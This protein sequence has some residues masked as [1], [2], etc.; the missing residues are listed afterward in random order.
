MPI[1]I[2]DA[3][4]PLSDESL[5]RRGS[6]AE[7][8]LVESSASRVLRQELQ[9]YCEGKINGR[10]FLIAGHR[11]AGKTTLVAKAFMDVH[12]LA[13]D[14]AP[15]RRPLFIALHGP[16]LFPNPAAHEPGGATPTSKNEPNGASGTDGPPAVSADPGPGVAKPATGQ[17]IGKS[18]AQIALEQITLGLHRA[19]AQEF[20]ARY[21]ER[22]MQLSWLRRTERLET[23]RLRREWPK[24]VSSTLPVGVGAP[25]VADLRRLLGGLPSDGELFELAGQ[26]EVE[27]YESPPVHRLRQFWDRLRALSGGVLFPGGYSPLLRRISGPQPPPGMFL[28]MTE[29]HAQGARELVALAG[30]LEAY[31]RIS[32]DYTRSEGEKSA[33]QDTK[34]RVTGFEAAGKDLAAPIAALLTGGLAGTGLALSGAGPGA[35]ALGGIAAAL[36]AS[37]VFKTT[38]TR[39][40]ERFASRE[41]QFVYDLSVSTLDRI[42]PILIERLNEAGLAPVFVVDELDKVRELSSRIV[43]M[44]HHLKKL[45]AEN[46]F[47]CFLT[48]RSYFEEMLAQGSGRPYPVEYTYYTHRLFVVFAPEDFEVYLRKRIP[49]PGPNDPATPATLT[50][51]VPPADAQVDVEPAARAILLWALR[52]RSQLHM[53]DLQREISALRDDEGRV[54]VLPKLLTGSRRNLIDMTFQVGIELTLGQPDVEQMLLD[55]PEFRRLMHDAMYYMSR[56]WL[57]GQQVQLSPSGRTLFLDYLERRTGREEERAPADPAPQ[58]QP[59]PQRIV[60]SVA[61]KDLEFLFD[62]VS[63]LADFLGDRPSADHS[64]TATGGKP[65][66]W[67]KD[68]LAAWNERRKNRGL[69]EVEPDVLD[70]LLVGERTSILVPGQGPESLFRFR[71]PVAVGTGEATQP[72]VLDPSVPAPTALPPMTPTLAPT[73][74][75]S[76][77]PASPTERSGPV[78]SVEWETKATFLEGF[79]DAL[80]A[81]VLSRTPAAGSRVSPDGAITLDALAGRFRIMA[82]SPTW[83]VTRDAIA[84]LRDAASRGTPHPGYDEDVFLVDQFHEILVRN[85]EQILRALLLG[86]VV[87]SASTGSQEARIANGL[88]VIT[89]AMRFARKQETDVGRALENVM[90]LVRDAKGED[91]ETVVEGFREE[92]AEIRAFVLRMRVGLD[93]VAALPSVDE[94]E[95][96]IAAWAGCHSRL[97]RWVT[98]N[99]VP[100]PGFPELVAAALRRGPTEL[101]D[102]DPGDMTL[103]Q[104]TRA[105]VVARTGPHSWLTWV[106]VG[107]SAMMSAWSP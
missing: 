16:S 104:W 66:D 46:A 56:L 83:S 14:G 68:R 49:A 88:G 6:T 28:N 61:D 87:G 59:Q 100:E 76:G 84:R 70:A 42:L 30:V 67:R 29:V 82:P 105:L 35:T 43:T 52:H 72:A 90:A 25:D 2:V 26:F 40:R 45:V 65:R 98:T 11:G 57:E 53:V 7:P 51:P 54:R 58:P 81:A 34:E 55:R 86:A 64:R 48:N 44:V 103:Q 85:G 79:A 78:L 91:L 107:R 74:G 20:S 63:I 18:E 93:R 19:V 89:R 96:V 12:R 3:P 8:L 15:M 73:D 102:F 71:Y 37:L 1:V 4:E 36:G 69:A 97:A 31:R 39:K 5:S 21:R 10:S 99:E 32:G 47:F 60:A 95:V 77:Q 106:P 62:Q 94:D 24:D 101:L 27:L 22:A 80:N 17:P 92:W 33:R 38:T 9:R 50:P 23:D 13:E 41:Y 75:T